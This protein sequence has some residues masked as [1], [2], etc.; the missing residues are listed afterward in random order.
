MGRGI[1]EIGD[2]KIDMLANAAS[3]VIYRRIFHKDFIMQMD[4]KGEVD[5]NA[6]SEMGFVMYM[7]TQKT[8]KEIVD[9]VTEDAFYEWLAQF[10]ALDVVMAAGAIFAL[11]KGQEK[12]LVTQKKRNRKRSGNRR[13]H[14]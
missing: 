8:F 12:T 6:I 10:E 2:K 5:T 4:P 11:F 1:V 9:T 14:S 7:Q 13:P 3:P